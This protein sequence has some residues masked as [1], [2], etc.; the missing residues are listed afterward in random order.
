MRAWCRPNARALPTT[1]VLQSQHVNVSSLI[2][3]SLLKAVALDR[4]MKVAF[5]T[6]RPTCQAGA[7]FEARQWLLRETSVLML[8]RGR[9]VEGCQPVSSNCVCGHSEK[10]TKERTR[11]LRQFSTWPF[12]FSGTC[13]SARFSKWS[14]RAQKIE[15]IYRRTVPRDSGK[16]ILLERWANCFVAYP[17]VRTWAA[18]V[19]CVP[20]PC[21]TE[22]ND[23]SVSIS[24]SV[25][26]FKWAR[27]KGALFVSRY[28]HAVCCSGEI[29]RP[30]AGD[31]WRV[32]IPSFRRVYISK[33][34]FISVRVLTGILVWQEFAAAA[35][36]FKL[37][38]VL[39]NG[40][41]TFPRGSRVSRPKLR[42]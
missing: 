11:G 40:L 8:I 15:T 20:K 22:Q 36:I 6:T 9:R 3:Q 42:K 30:T 2:R 25:S 12:R 27:I 1:A 5:S 38:Y 32:D 24:H 39:E 13:T 14:R 10:R 19:W 7:R 23:C 28:F 21:P 37:Y 26:S 41:N 35:T 4:E 31:C 18:Y 33:R 29:K 17:C 16:M 34:N